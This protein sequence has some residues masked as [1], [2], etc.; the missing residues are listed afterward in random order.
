MWDTSMTTRTPFLVISA[1]HSPS[2]A[3]AM[4]PPQGNV[5]SDPLFGWWKHEAPGPCVDKDTIACRHAMVR[6]P[7]AHVHVAINRFGA[8]GHVCITA[9]VIYSLTLGY[10]LF[11]I[12]MAFRLCCERS[13]NKLLKLI[14]DHVV[15]QLDTKLVKAKCPHEQPKSMHDPDATVDVSPQPSE[16]QTTNYGALHPNA[17]RASETRTKQEHNRSA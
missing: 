11:F 5:N 7:T 10:C 1:L 17:T 13:C 8:F 3:F 15:S 14:C 9:F 12:C 2:C 6:T 4:V 16:Q